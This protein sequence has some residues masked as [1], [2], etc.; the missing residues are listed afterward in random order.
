MSQHVAAKLCAVRSLVG[1]GLGYQGNQFNVHGDDSDS[2]DGTDEVAG[3]GD[4][5]TLA[6]ISP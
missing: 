5:V 6:W 3:D 4:D 2:D 1:L